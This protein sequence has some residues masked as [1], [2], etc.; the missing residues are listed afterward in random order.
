MTNLFQSVIS[1]QST[2]DISQSAFFECLICSIVLGIVISLIYSF[3]NSASKSFIVTLAVLPAIVQMVIMLV[4]GSIGTGIAVMGAFNLVRFRSAPGTAKEITCVF[5]AMA[6]GLAA[7]MGYL[8]F[9]VVF[10]AVI[11]A[12]MIVFDIIG[13]GDRESLKKDLRITVPE[14]LD[15]SGAFDDLFEKYL[16]SSELVEVKTSNMG[17]LY[18]LRYRVLFKNPKAEKEFIDE[19]RCRNGNLEISC[20]KTEFSRDT[21]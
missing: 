15:Y 8:M 13:F 17:S 10:V 11:G 7:G 4:D 5:L 18:K 3:K 16:K 9:A 14:S 20:C 1:S 19:L 21:L 2:T 6:V 12:L